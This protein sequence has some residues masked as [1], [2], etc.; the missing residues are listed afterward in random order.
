MISYRYQLSLIFFCSLFFSPVSAQQP[1]I[2]DDAEVY[3]A[4]IPNGI[5]FSDSDWSTI[6][7]G[8]PQ[9][10]HGSTYTVTEKLDAR[11]VFFF[12]GKLFALEISASSDAG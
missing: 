10:H 3:S 11:L 2:V 1:E 9:K 12:R 4:A 5:Q 7:A 6:D 8:D